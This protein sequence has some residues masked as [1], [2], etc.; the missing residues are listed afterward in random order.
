MVK[1]APDKPC[2]VRDDYLIALVLKPDD[3]EYVKLAFT[4]NCTMSLSF[5]IQPFPLS[6]AYIHLQQVHDLV[7]AT[8]TDKSQDIIE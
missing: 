1:T 8:F 2:R 4:L 3:F 7:R 5:P 6:R